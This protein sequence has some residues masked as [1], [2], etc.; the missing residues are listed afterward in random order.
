MQSFTVNVTDE[1]FKALAWDILDVTD[2][3]SN[4]TH[5]KAR[6]VIDRILV[7]AF[8]DETDTIITKE[9]KNKIQALLHAAGFNILAIKSWPDHIKQAAVGYANLQSAAERLAE[10]EP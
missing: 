10:M 3:I 2:W 8:S 6:K 1:E 5:D 9:D 7:L 4:F